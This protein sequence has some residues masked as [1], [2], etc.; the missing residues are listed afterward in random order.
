MHGAHA[1]VVDDHCAQ[2]YLAGCATRALEPEW[3]SVFK[4][5]QQRASTLGLEVYV[6]PERLFHRDLRCHSE[7]RSGCRV[8]TGR[9]R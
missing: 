7:N 3:V 2:L 1:D 9:V 6:E 4:V 8:F 5:T